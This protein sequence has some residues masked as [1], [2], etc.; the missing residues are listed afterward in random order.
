MMIVMA[1]MNK[2]MTTMTFDFVLMMRVNHDNDDDNFSKFAVSLQMNHL[3][4][5]KRGSGKQQDKN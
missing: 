2:T 5:E 1:I 3:S 4:R